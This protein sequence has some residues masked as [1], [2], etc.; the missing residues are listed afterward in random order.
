VNETSRV[1]TVSFPGA[2]Q[3]ERERD[4]HLA[5]KLAAF[6]HMRDAPWTEIDLRVASPLVERWLTSHEKPPLDPVDLYEFRMAE[7]RDERRRL[8]RSHLTLSWFALA[9]WTY[10]LIAVLSS[11][12]RAN[13][14]APE[15]FVDAVRRYMLELGVEV[16]HQECAEEID[17]FVPR[18][19]GPESLLRPD[20]TGENLQEATSK[21]LE[22][23]AF[24]FVSFV[25]FLH[26][27]ALRRR[28]V[29]S[30]SLALPG[31]ALTFVDADAKQARNVSTFLATHGVPVIQPDAV[32]D[33][34]N[35]LLVLLSRQAMGSDAFWK[36]M[37]DWQDRDVV[38]MVLCL[39][40]KAEL[41][42]APPTSS[43][44]HAAWQWLSTSVALELTSK[45]ERYDILLRALDSVDSQQWWWMR[46]DAVELGI[47]VDVLRTGIPR[48]AVRSKTCGPTGIPYP[49]NFNDDLLLGCVFASDH[50]ERHHA[51]QQDKRYTE[52]CLHLERLRQ[53]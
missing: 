19:P 50:L 4:V 21:N 40:P 37:K 6:V 26:Y 10:R 5:V 52:R 47:S 3:L 9:Y 22:Y 48:P 29:I 24:A 14:A 28:E 7:L 16:S 12:S 23:S 18:D 11:N 32:F 45:N 1:D 35:R 33:P 46:G 42:A 30:P 44:H 34:T 8:T 20:P 2:D 43:V 13:H 53:G 38:P 41:Y 36:S 49:V 51:G 27:R 31:V 15:M 25:R 17:R 39:M